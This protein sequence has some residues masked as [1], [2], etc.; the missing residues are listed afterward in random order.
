MGKI[1]SDYIVAV[2]RNE[3]LLECLQIHLQKPITL[4]EELKAMVEDPNRTVYDLQCKFSRDYKFTAKCWRICYPNEYDLSYLSSIKPPVIKPYSELKQIWLKTYCNYILSYKKD[5]E[6]ESVYYDVDKAKMLAE[7]YLQ[8]FKTEEKESFFNECIR[9]IDANEIQTTS[10]KISDRK[11][12]LMYSKENI[13]WSNFSHTISDD[14]KISIA[15]NFGYG[16]SAYFFLSVKYK[17]LEIIPY[18]FIVKYYKAYMMDILRCTRSFKVRRESWEV[19][20]DFVVDMANQAQSNPDDFIKKYVMYEVQ[21]MMVG[22]KAIVDNPQDYQKSI[23]NNVSEHL[24][25]VRNILE[26]EKIRMRAY[27][28]ECLFIFKVEK[29]TAALH[30]LN[31]LSNIALNFVDI[32]QDINEHI[33]TLLSYNFEIY[34]EILEQCEELDKRIE[35]ERNELSIKESKRNYV[36]CSLKPYEEELEAICKDMKPWERREKENVFQKSNPEYVRLLDEKQDLNA[37]IAEHR[38]HINEYLNFNVMLQEAM[39]LI[40]SVREVA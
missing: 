35:K 14:L 27:P 6:S 23:C 26:N 24:V 20:F 30:F 5:C 2:K 21:E 38:N 4:I 37:K 12:I 31:S 1:S 7:E 8:E 9:W 32:Q 15:T 3:N 40:D 18:S 28:E 13:G 34:P 39:K 19:S 10:N 11:D 16:R 25:N 17:N 36:I 33:K 22:L 29:L